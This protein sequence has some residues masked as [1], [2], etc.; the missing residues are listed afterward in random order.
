M[1]KQDFLNGLQKLE[2]HKRKFPQSYELI[3][4][5]KGLNLKK[6]EEQVEVFLELPHAPRKE[7]KVAALVGGELAE[8]AKEVCDAAITTDDFIKYGDKKSIKQL[9]RSYDF[10]IAQANIMPQVAKQFGRVFGPHGK[11]PNPKVGCVVPP[12]ANLSP[13][14]ERLK[15]TIR[16]AAK[17]DASVKVKVGYEGQDLNHIAE[18][19]AA[20]YHAVF[21]KLPQEINNIKNVM[22]KKT[23]SPPVKIEEA[24]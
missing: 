5:L 7:T 24:K 12:N 13:L 3:I 2:E 19:M 8:H 21:A 6:P 10:F 4:N 20:V 1:K 14:V 23:M 15:T 9:S 17:V 11:M 18:N 22:I 16:A